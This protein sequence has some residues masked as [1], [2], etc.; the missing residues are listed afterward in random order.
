MC[1]CGCVCVC[2]RTHSYVGPFKVLLAC[3]NLL[4][5]NGNFTVKT[6]VGQ[7]NLGRWRLDGSKVLL[8]HGIRQLAYIIG[9]VLIRLQSQQILV[10]LVLQ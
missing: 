7:K 9:C 4:P 3:V 6:N 8:L 2:G 5:N 10:F 1:M